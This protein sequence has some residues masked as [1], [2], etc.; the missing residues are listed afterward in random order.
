[1]TL[2]VHWATNYFGVGNS[3]G[4]F[5]HDSK[6]RQ[7][8]EDA[9]VV[10]DGNAPVSLHVCPPH[11]FEPIPG[12]KSIAY[13]AWE[14]PE[15]PELFR[16]KMAPADA[17]CVTASFLKA[18]FEQMFP[19]KPVHVVPLGVDW[20]V[21]T[22]IDRSSAKFRPDF[23]PAPRGRPFR[24]MWCGA[25]N[26]RK[27]PLHLLE[28][29]KVFAEQQHASGYELY[30]KTSMPDDTKEDICVKRVGNIIVDTR[31]LP[32]R[33]LVSLYHR[34]HCFVFP[35]K[36][37][38]FGLTMAE[39][40]ATGLPVI[41][42]PWTSLPDIANPDCAYPLPL[43][44]KEADWSWPNADARGTPMEAHVTTADPHPA[45][46]A[47]AMLKVLH[48]HEE[49]FRRGHLASRRIREHFRWD[50]CGAKLR[51][52]VEEV[53]RGLDSGRQQPSLPSKE[54]ELCPN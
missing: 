48:D 22:E 12:K 41:Y 33:D 27:G 14:A 29:W 31:K 32:L 42:T 20:D 18:P 37:E 7:A 39:A 54:R 43:R 36:G 51:S 46:I 21:F 23:R 13:V 8:T 47:E 49:A 17:I 34:A 16:I 24:F 2:A 50:Q 10:I 5:T 1:M 45:E 53:Y 38:G 19:C 52:V 3:F 30:L 6:A 4:Y 44:T 25:A 9:G 35:T 15:L 11:R 40:M 28:A 26:S